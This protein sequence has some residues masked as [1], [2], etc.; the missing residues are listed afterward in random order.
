MIH[1]QENQSGVDSYA[2]SSFL[3][4]NFRIELKIIRPIPVLF[5]AWEADGA[6]SS[7]FGL[8]MSS[9]EHCTDYIK[10][11]FL[12]MNYLFFQLRNLF[13]NFFGEWFPI[14]NET[15]H[16]ISLISFFQEGVSHF[17]YFQANAHQTCKMLS[18]NKIIWIRNRV[19][20]NYL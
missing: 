9:Q 12:I 19:L 14:C 4:R 20:Q 6:F 1:L 5:N 13:V 2:W 8:C 17:H 15:G 18:H 7:H 16:C 10:N 3:V 11:L